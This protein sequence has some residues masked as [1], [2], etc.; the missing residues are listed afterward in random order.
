MF[1]LGLQCRRNPV[2]AV[3]MFV[4]VG[5]AALSVLAVALSLL[6]AALA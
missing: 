5:F 6:A 4:V 3:I 2:H 1:D